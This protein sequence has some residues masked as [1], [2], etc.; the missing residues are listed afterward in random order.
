MLAGSG[1]AY[2]ELDSSNQKSLLSKLANSLV[3]NDKVHPLSKFAA[4]GEFSWAEGH[5]IGSG[6]IQMC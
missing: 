3:S 4:A 1:R 6:R 5:S 2:H